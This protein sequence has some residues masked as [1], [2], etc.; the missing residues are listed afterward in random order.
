MKTY[1]VI[2]TVTEAFVLILGGAVFLTMAIFQKRFYWKKGISAGGEA[3]RWVG[4]VICGIVGLAFLLV[5]FRFV[6]LGY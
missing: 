3:P 6:L 5:G 1:A 4:R 2:T